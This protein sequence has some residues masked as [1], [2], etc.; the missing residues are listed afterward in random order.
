MKTVMQVIVIDVSSKHRKLY[1]DN[2]Q[3][4]RYEVIDK[5]LK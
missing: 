2:V 5:T 3:Y 4:T 1:R